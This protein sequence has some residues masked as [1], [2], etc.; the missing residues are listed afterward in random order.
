MLL[1]SKLY[2]CFEELSRFDNI[3]DR[4]VNEVKRLQ[5]QG[6]LDLATP[7]VARSSLASPVDDI[8]AHAFGQQLAALESALSSRMEA[9]VAAL[10]VRLMTQLTKMEL[11]VD[12]VMTL[13]ATVANRREASPASS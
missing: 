3:A 9:A 2:F 10:E 6:A 11:K 12:H 13:L 5:A 1:G 4:L 8:V 7:T